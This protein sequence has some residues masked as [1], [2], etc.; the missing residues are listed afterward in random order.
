MQAEYLGIKA[1]IGGTSSDESQRK[2]Q[3]IVPPQLTAQRLATFIGQAG[4]CRVL[5][6]FHKMP[7]AEKTKLSQL[8]KVFMD[9][10]VEFPRLK[11]VAIGAVNTARQIVDYDAEMA[12][13]VAEIPVQLMTRPEL[14]IILAKGEQHLNISVSAEVKGGISHYCDGL[15]SVCHQLALNACVAARECS[16]GVRRMS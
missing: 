3:R 10:A 15:A 16:T 7:A 11:I 14:A 6:D 5:E 4:C 12:N 1:K 9:M 8:M 13:R 2:Q